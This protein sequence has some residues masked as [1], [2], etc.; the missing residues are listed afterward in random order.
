MLIGHTSGGVARVGKTKAVDTIESG[1][2][3]STFGGAYLAKHYGLTNVV[4]F[5]VG[6]TTTK[7]SI[8]KDGHPVFQR[9]GNWL[10][11]R[12]KPPLPCCARR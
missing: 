5:D 11:S 3:F 1:P 7:A 9:G 8:V 6:G 10:A 4:C 2:I 12:S